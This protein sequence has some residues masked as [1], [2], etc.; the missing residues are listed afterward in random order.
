MV[1]NYKETKDLKLEKMNI[2]NW[3][4]QGEANKGKITAI[5]PTGSN[6]HGNSVEWS[7]RKFYKGSTTYSV[8][9]GILLQW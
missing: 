9:V 4:I 6:F 5:S 8:K 2:R 1:A 3:W 7:T